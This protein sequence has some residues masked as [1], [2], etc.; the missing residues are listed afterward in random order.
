MALQLQRTD[1]ERDGEPLPL[2]LVPNVGAHSVVDLVDSGVITHVKLDLVCR[3]LLEKKNQKDLYRRM[4]QDS[5]G[6][7]SRAGQYVLYQ[8]GRH[9]ILEPD[10]DTHSVDFSRVMEIDDRLFNDLVVWNVEINGI[11][12]AQPGRAPV[13]LHHFGEALAELHPVNQCSA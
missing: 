13:D 12:R 2:K 11:V 1:G 6:A 4:S 5:V 3:L 10:T 7:R 9:P 8:I